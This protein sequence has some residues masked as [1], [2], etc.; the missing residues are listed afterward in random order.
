[1]E[2]YVCQYRLD[3]TIIPT[4]D[5]KDPKLSSPSAECIRGRLR[6]VSAPFDQLIRQPSPNTPAAGDDPGLATEENLRWRE[7]FP[8]YQ[9]DVGPLMK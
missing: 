6:T 2:K 8:S 9:P 5:L 3:A 7:L 4:V 1:M